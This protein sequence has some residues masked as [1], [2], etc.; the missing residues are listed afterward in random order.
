[1]P[2]QAERGGGRGIAP[3]HSQRGTRRRWVAVPRFGHF[4]PFQDPVWVAR[5]I[6]SSPKFDPRTVQPLA[7]RYTDYAV[8]TAVPNQIRPLCHPFSLVFNIIL[9]NILK[10]PVDNTAGSRAT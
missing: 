5:K 9:S 1:M 4:V 6:S 3:T 2:M 8:P 7:S 10:H